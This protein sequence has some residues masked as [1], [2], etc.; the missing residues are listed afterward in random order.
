MKRLIAALAIVAA[1]AFATL[2]DT[3]NGRQSSIANGVTT[4]YTFFFPVGNATDVTATVTV[5]GVAQGNSF[6]VAINSDQISAPGG[7]VTFSIAPV[8]GATVRIQRAELLTQ[9][10]I[11]NPYSPF[12]AKTTE[13]TFDGAVRKIQQVDRR[14]ADLETKEASDISNTIAGGIG[15]VNLLA[16]IT[17]GTTAARTLPDR[18]NDYGANP[19]DFNTAAGDG[20]TD[21]ASAIQSAVNKAVNIGGVTDKNGRVYLPCGTYIINSTIVLQPTYFGVVIEGENQN[22]TTIR[23]GASMTAMFSY[24]DV[25]QNGRFQFRHLTI[26]ANG[27]AQ[28]GIKSTKFAY[29]KLEHMAVVGATVAGVYFTAGWDN[30]IIDCEF[31]LNTGDGFVLGDSQ[32]NDLQIENT[33]F[34]NNTGWGA[35]FYGGGPINIRGGA[36]QANAAGGFYVV[37]LGRP[38]HFDGIYFEAN[39]QTGH[40]FATPSKT[41][42]ADIIV[43]GTTLLN[44][45][46]YSFPSVNVTVNNCLF[47]STYTET[48]IYAIGAQAMNVK[49]NFNPNANI[50][51][52]K[53]WGDSTY[54]GPRNVEIQ[55]NNSFTKDL[56]I[57]SVTSNRPGF[58]ST[59]NSDSVT[60]L[61]YF[62]RSVYALSKWSSSSG[63]SQLARGASKF[64]GDESFDV[65]QGAGDAYGIVIDVTTANPELASK[66]VYISA[67][68][69]ASST[70]AGPRLH[71]GAKTSSGSFAVDTAWHHIEMEDYLPASGTVGVG[72]AKLGSTV[73]DIV[74]F[75]KV[76]VALIGAPDRVLNQYNLLPPV[77]STT[78]APTLGTWARGDVVWNTT[79]AAAGAPGWVCTAA[80]SP[81]TWKAM[82]NVAP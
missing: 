56:D 40:V 32:G 62:P 54:A 44:N 50:P 43:N 39:A 15:A 8:G 59:W 34:S 78:A 72:F 12:P 19:K 42:K 74:S 41:V 75:S 31:A 70:N 73:G 48:A 77:W 66:L 17:T 10:T 3:S 67:W 82:A 26:D 51:L 45:M 16:P 28:Y 69:K 63:T 33:L 57:D 14:V 5:A 65:D 24:T 4:A 36:S 35:K 60:R 7:T 23:A 2:Y 29:G 79:P 25:S 27:I 6:T 76:T 64:Q 80:G 13:R 30:R 71:I 68:A 1:P 46:N 53:T 38:V 58:F 61:N 47:N 22:C 81:G 9:E 52:L 49:G 21:V 37:A 20:L 55:G 11:F 18:F